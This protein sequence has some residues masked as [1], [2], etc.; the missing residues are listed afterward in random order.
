MYYIVKGSAERDCWAGASQWQH[1]NLFFD[2]GNKTA[3]K[4]GNYLELVVVAFALRT[5]FDVTIAFHSTL[6][7][8][9]I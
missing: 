4:G 7:Q 9:L 3:L 5:A 8:I 1:A 6:L 2:Q